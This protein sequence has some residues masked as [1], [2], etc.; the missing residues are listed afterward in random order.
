MA[1]RHRSWQFDLVRLDHT[2]AIFEA[3]PN[4]QLA[5]LPNST[6]LEPYDDAALVD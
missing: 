1:H 6:H 5:V 3:L 2:V 4:A